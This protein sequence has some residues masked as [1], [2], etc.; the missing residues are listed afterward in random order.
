MKRGHAGQGQ[1]KRKKGDGG[2]GGKGGTG[3]RGPGGMFA[4]SRTPSKPMD[5]TEGVSFKKEEGGNR[6]EKKQGLSGG[7]RKARTEQG[8]CKRNIHPR[9]NGGN[10]KKK[11]KTEGKKVLSPER[12]TQIVLNLPKYIKK[13]K[14]SKK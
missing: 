10:A 14:G 13:K 5:V 3:Q 4:P 1:G 2:T 6:G 9:L 11:K 12:G 8:P 7:R